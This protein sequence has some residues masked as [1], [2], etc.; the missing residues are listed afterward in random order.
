ML[1]PGEVPEPGRPC[2]GA[3][4]ARHG[5]PGPVP[6]Q[7]R[8][9]ALRGA[10]ALAVVAVGITALVYGV[11]VEG[12]RYA[13]RP[14]LAP[15]SP[16]EAPTQ[17]RIIRPSSCSLIAIF[18]DSPVSALILPASS[19]VAIISGRRVPVTEQPNQTQMPP[20]VTRLPDTAGH[21]LLTDWISVIP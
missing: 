17:P 1:M 10:I 18:V 2:C 14:D 9:G 16:G 11:R 12:S 5:P 15:T 20:L 3:L 21:K 19:F 6:A 8:T 13:A 7:R 4:P